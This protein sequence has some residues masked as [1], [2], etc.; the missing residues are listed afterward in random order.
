[1]KSLIQNVLKRIVVA[2]D[3]INGVDRTGVQG[4]TLS[5]SEMDAIHQ[6]MVR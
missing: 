4:T 1:M 5:P 3:Y 6:T 2:I